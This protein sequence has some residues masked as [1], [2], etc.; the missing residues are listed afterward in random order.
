MDFKP[1]SGGKSVA[2]GEASLASE[3]PGKSEMKSSRVSGGRVF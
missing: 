2:R 1:R 3:T